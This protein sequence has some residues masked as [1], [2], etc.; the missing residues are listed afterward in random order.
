M[1]HGVRGGKEEEEEKP[2]DGVEGTRSRTEEEDGREES[3]RDARGESDD[4][5]EDRRGQ[6]EKTPDPECSVQEKQ[7]QTDR[8]KEASGEASHVP[9]G[10]HSVEFYFGV[11][12]QEPKLSYILLTCRRV[13]GGLLPIYGRISD[14]KD[15]VEPPSSQQ[16]SVCRITSRNTAWQSLACLVVLV[17][18]DRQ[19][20][21]PPRQRR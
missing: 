8:E 12:S 2:D 20:P 18:Q 19:D 10:S 15:A 5:K 21:S 6:R 14:S 9:A 11:R 4:Q 1:D 17:M 3:Q 16:D 13:I 7:P